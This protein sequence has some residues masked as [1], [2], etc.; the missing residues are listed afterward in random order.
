M[1]KL[2]DLFNESKNTN[3]YELI[4][5]LTAN[6]T[7]RTLGD[8]LSDMRAIIGVTI[9]RG[10]GH[11]SDVPTNNPSYTEEIKIKIDPYPFGSFGKEQVREIINQIKHID[12]VTTFIPS[13]TARKISEIK[14]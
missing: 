1:I 3:L 2:V 5:K 8:I 14:K 12:G 4:G 10:E 9:V 7:K 11:S 13:T 6:T